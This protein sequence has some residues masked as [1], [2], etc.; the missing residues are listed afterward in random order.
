MPGGVNIWKI[1]SLFHDFTKESFAASTTIRQDTDSAGAT[2]LD[3]ALSVQNPFERTAEDRDSLFDIAMEATYANR[4]EF[5]E[6][7]FESI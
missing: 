2:R 6:A 7:N 3:I 5:V 1:E 4:L